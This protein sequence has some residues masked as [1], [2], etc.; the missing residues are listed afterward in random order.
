MNPEIS[1]LI[2]THNQKFLLERCLDSILSQIINVP[3][4]IIISDDGIDDG[5]REFVQKLACS[6]RV[7]S[8]F[9]LVELKYLYCDLDESI[10]LKGG[11]EDWSE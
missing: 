5:T 9:N 3:Y 8:L 7:I 10:L 1:I 2:L 4:E 6:K 11:G